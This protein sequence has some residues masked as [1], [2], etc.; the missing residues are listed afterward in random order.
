MRRAQQHHGNTH[1]KSTAKLW[2][3]LPAAPSR[4]TRGLEAVLVI[5]KV[6]RRASKAPNL[7]SLAVVEQLQ[8]VWQTP[9]PSA[10]DTAAAQVLSAVQAGLTIELYTPGMHETSNAAYYTAKPAMQCTARRQPAATA[11]MPGRS[12]P[13][14]LRCLA[15]PPPRT[16]HLAAW[17]SVCMRTR[18]AEQLSYKSMQGR[19]GLTHPNRTR[20]RAL[21]C[22]TCYVACPTAPAKPKPHPNLLP[23]RAPPA[24]PQ[25]TPPH[26]NLLPQRALQAPTPPRHPTATRPAPPHLHLPLA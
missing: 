6:K 23:Q 18:G 24:S 13:L 16:P 4:R 21:P 17:S 1:L 10:S 11:R 7:V 15:A 9:S 8:L 19:V 22:V 5:A 14:C 3:S 2:K 12:P 26:P 20:Q 25:P